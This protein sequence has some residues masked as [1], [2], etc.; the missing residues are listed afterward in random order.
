MLQITYSIKYRSKTK[1]RILSML[2]HCTDLYGLINPE[3]FLFGLI[4]TVWELR[5][6]YF[7]IEV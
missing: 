3:A 6:S 4:T 1:C 7:A 2:K 5:E